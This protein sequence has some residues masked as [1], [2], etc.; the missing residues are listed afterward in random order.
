[1]NAIMAFGGS[2]PSGKLGGAGYVTQIG[3]GRGRPRNSESLSDG[4][5]SFA[6]RKK[7]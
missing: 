6:L 1:M 5:W 4:K 2:E 3:H 7:M